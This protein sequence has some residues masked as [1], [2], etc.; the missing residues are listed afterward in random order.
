M[1]KRKSRHKSLQKNGFSLLELL[2]VIAILGVLVSLVLPGFSGAREDAKD[3]VA[4]AEM[5]EIQ[6]AFRRF[7]A[8]VGLENYP[9]KL[10]DI[11]NYGLWPLLQEE[12]PRGATY[13][14]DNP[15]VKYAEYDAV[16]GIGRR[17][18][19]LSWE[20]R[21]VMATPTG[22]TAAAEPVA[23][24]QDKVAAG[25]TIPVVKDTYGGYYRVICPIITASDTAAA[26]L[27]KY[28]KL[29][30]I[31]TGVN[32]VWDTTPAH[33]YDDDDNFRLNDD[34]EITPDNRDDGNDDI[35]IRLLPTATW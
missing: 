4:R 21:E 26:K 30:L 6:S 8:D 27:R 20:G 2:I 13:Q 3:K 24:G 14:A 33:L 23:P 25:T 19:Y 34:G 15:V 28:K 17:G 31:C 35:I 5:Q 16:T 18:P 22:D 7:S 9:A 29:V 10:K 11:C 12:H 32:G 1:S